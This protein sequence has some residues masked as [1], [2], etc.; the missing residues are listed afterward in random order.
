MTEAIRPIIIR[1]KKVY[2]ADGHHGG[3]WKVAYA[4]F[5]TAMMAFFLLMWLLNATTE[6]QRKGIADYFSPN[7]PLASVS[8]G[9][10]EA[11]S[12]D[13]VFTTSKMAQSGTGAD[14][15]NAK[16]QSSFYE[17]EAAKLDAEEIEKQLDAM[18]NELEMLDP[19]L[20][21]QV[22]I[23]MSPEGI[24]IELVDQKDSPLFNSG[25]ATPSSVLT[26]LTHI[27]VDSLS[28][29]G[30]EIKIVGHT[31]K[32][33]FVNKADYSNW[34]LSTDRANS[35]RRLLAKN[36]FPLQ[37]VA[38][39]SGKAA[40]EPLTNDPYSAQNRRISITLLTPQSL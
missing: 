22:M 35:A 3:A 16:R 23:H 15:D 30:N 10:S 33:S 38:E 1:R 2:A 25:S 26:T 14:H 9:G 28:G 37:Q 12:G 31:D 39:V 21:E 11:L 20:A 19:G 7:I 36:G 29:I 13:T 18:N 17:D 8:G 27:L 24:V 40:T 5:V 32:H 6:E 34:D 4:D